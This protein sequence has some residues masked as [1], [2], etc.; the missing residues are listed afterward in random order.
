MLLS[1]TAS[2][3]LEDPIM[4]CA[5]K[6]IECRKALLSS[7][8]TAGALRLMPKLGR[9]AMDSASTLATP[10]HQRSVTHVSCTFRHQ[11]YRAHRSD[12]NFYAPAAIAEGIQHPK[13]GPRL[14]QNHADHPAAPLEK[15]CSPRVPDRILGLSG[16]PPLPD[17]LAGDIAGSRLWLCQRRCKVCKASCES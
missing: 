4:F 2:F 6:S 1:S 9:G 17:E 11:S 12:R 13:P 5:G 3:T 15:P 14:R 7:F 8:L 10:E 16:E